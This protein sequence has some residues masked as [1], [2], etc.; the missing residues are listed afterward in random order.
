MKRDMELIRELM[1]LIESQ[2]ESHKELTLP[3]NINREIAVYHLNLMEQAGFTKNKIVYGDNSPMWIYSSLT[4]NGHDFLDS[5]K[6]D[7]IWN[8][9]KDGI[10]TKGLELGQL[11]FGVIKDLAKIELKKR[12]GI[13]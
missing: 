5:I 9:V 1:F 13:E 8:K 12:L 3:S 7:S 2:D 4:W 6:N 11:S 10:K